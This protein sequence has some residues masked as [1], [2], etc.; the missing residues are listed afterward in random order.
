M[1]TTL[2]PSLSPILGGAFSQSLGWRSIFWFLVIF[3]AVLFVLTLIFFPET[4]RKIVDNGSVPPPTWNKSLLNHIHERRLRKE[5]MLSNSTQQGS[6]AKNQR[7][8]FPD[9]FSTI[10]VLADK[11]QFLLLFYAGVIYAGFYA[12]S[13]TI[14]TQ[15]RAIYGL[16]DL[17]LGLCFI[18]ISVGGIL[19]TVTN[20]K[21]DPIDR[22]YARYAKRLN[23]P[24]TKN[25]RQDISNFPIERARL[26]IL[27][28]LMIAGSLFTVG[29]GWLLQ[30]ETNL[31]APLVLLTFIGFF[32]SAAF[33]VVTILNIDLAE[34]KAGT[35][36]A[37]F[38]L[39]RCL[40]GAG[41]TAV[42]DLIFKAMG[43]GWTFTFI[44]LVQ[45]ALSPMLLAIIKWGP[46]W[47]KEKAERKRN[48]KEQNRNL[49]AAQEAEK[50]DQA[51]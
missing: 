4:C 2:G 30:A 25:R 19:A 7:F 13:A 28:P 48:K 14:T 11:E 50:G 40:L 31:A 5:G 47:R 10:R 27:L 37:S 18:P 44:G 15:F 8:R 24:L 29:Y 51:Q 32:F 49:E 35:A 3:G 1:A 36:S 6:L 17:K 21:Y 9:P 42:I 34:G 26:E 23:M 46:G 38:N 41:S 43:R 16:N 20:G 12:I 45:I 33:K 39:I 22:N